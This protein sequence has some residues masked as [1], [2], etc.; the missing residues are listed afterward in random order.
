M[1]IPGGNTFYETIQVPVIPVPGSIDS[2]GWPHLWQL[3]DGTRIFH[4]AQVNILSKLNGT[5]DMQVR[6]EI[7]P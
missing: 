7:Y 3:A 1:E 4:P 2:E 5:V 6:K